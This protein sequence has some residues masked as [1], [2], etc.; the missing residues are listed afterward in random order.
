MILFS[1]S[2]KSS[3]FVFRLITQDRVYVLSAGSEIDRFAWTEK[4]K[5]SLTKAR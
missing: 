5:E 2:G 4:L 1:I 3:G